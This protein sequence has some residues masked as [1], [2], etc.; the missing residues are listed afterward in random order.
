MDETLDLSKNEFGKGRMNLSWDMVMNEMSPPYIVKDLFFQGEKNILFGQGGTGKSRMIVDMAVSVILGKSSLYGLPINKFEKTPN[1]LYFCL[2]DSVFNLCYR[3]NYLPFTIDKN[4]FNKIVKHL[5]VFDRIKTDDESFLKDIED[6][7]I[8][9]DIDIVIVDT[10]RSASNGNN[11]ESLT[12]KNDIQMFDNMNIRKD[13]TKI[14][15]SH[16]NRSGTPV[17]SGAYTDLVRHCVNI[18]TESKNGQDI[19]TVRVYKSNLTQKNRKLFTYYMEDLNLILLTNDELE[20]EYSYKTISE[21]LKKTNGI[22]VFKD[23]FS[24]VLKDKKYHN[25]MNDKLKSVIGNG[26][27]NPYNRNQQV[28]EWKGNI[29]KKDKQGILVSKEY[30]REGN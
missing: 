14:F 15:I 26:K 27:L 18:D 17:G 20:P 29:E 5:F 6:F 19:S 2:E 7:I 4:D 23:Y 21:Y 3:F 12:A 16:H 8:K 22:L 25:R 10:L 11:N 30:I 24:E 9:N 28:T 1:I 13:I